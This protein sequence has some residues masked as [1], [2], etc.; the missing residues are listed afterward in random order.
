MGKDKRN[1]TTGKSAPEQCGQQSRK[2]IWE[3]SIVKSPLKE[4]KSCDRKDNGEYLIDN[5]EFV[6]SA[7]YFATK[8]IRLG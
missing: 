8:H 4:R 7:V 5:Y 6:A 1:A 3:P 2:K